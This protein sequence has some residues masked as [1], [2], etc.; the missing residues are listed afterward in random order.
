MSSV[1]NDIEDAIKNLIIEHMT[2]YDEYIVKKG[3]LDTAFRETMTRYADNP[4]F[5]VINHRGGYISLETTTFD[6]VDWRH[7]LNV[8]FYIPLRAPTMTEELEETMRNEYVQFLS[9]I[10]R[11]RFC[12]RGSRMYV[13][14]AYPPEVVRV[15]EQDYI[16]LKYAVEAKESLV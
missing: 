3:D 13:S 12:V 2:G 16:H 9:T 1:Y 14:R 8:S 7:T 5:C 11:N 15:A 4:R 10:A 6:T